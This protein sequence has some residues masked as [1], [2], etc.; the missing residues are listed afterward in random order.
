M[1]KKTFRLACMFVSLQLVTLENDVHA[2]SVHPWMDLCS[3]L[4]PSNTRVSA[5]IPLVGAW[6]V[7]PVVGTAQRSD[8]GCPCLTQLR[9]C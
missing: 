8:P 3:P 4:H 2:S 5:C 9:S 6:G 7:G 1:V